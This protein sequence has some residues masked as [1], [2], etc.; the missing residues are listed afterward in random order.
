MKRIGAI[1]FVCAFLAAMFAV[2]VSAQ[3]SSTSG[4]GQPTAGAAAVAE[5]VPP[6]A[7]VL[8]NILG[9]PVTNSMICTW[10]VAAIILIIVRATTL[11][12]YQ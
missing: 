12:K 8:F 3:P 6:A 1:I 5:H 2:S 9:L 7:P 11:E 4:M 10:I